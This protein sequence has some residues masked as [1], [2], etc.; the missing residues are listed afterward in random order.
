MPDWPWYK[1]VAMFLV[2]L[3]A[4]LWDCIRRALRLTVDDPG[5]LMGATPRSGHWPKIRA[6][7]LAKFP[8]CEVCGTVDKLDV[9]HCQPFHEHP[10]LECDP[11]NLITLC[12]DHHFLFGHLLAWP[13]HNPAVRED[14]A[15]WREKI[16]GRP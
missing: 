1:I 3:V 5:A 6:D 9:H 11:A 15:T 7:H 12:R 16:A 13:S 4:D 10:E 2:M 8:V 14:A